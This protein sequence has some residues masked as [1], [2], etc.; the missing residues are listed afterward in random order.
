MSSHLPEGYGVPR[1]KTSAMLKW[2]ADVEFDWSKDT[3]VIDEGLI[4]EI[5]EQVENAGVR[6][7]KTSAITDRLNVWKTPGTEEVIKS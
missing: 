4:A 2:T 6:R 7:A 5:A 1:A 3:P